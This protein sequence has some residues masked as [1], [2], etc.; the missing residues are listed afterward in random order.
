VNLATVPSVLGVIAL[1]F[2]AL[3]FVKVALQPAMDKPAKHLLLLLLAGMLAMAFCLFYIY[4]GMNRDW[5]RLASIEIGLAWWIGPSLYFYIRRLNGSAE[6][7]LRRWY[8][9]WVPA[10]AIE[11]LLL[12][13]FLR[14]IPG[15]ADLLGIPLNVSRQI[16]GYVWMGFHLQL[17]LYILLA[18]PQLRAYRRRLTDNYSDLSVLN[19]RWLTF[20][21]CGFLGVILAERLL[22]AIGVTS[23]SLSQ[24]AGSTV[25]LFVIVLMSGALGHSRLALASATRPE[26]AA[27]AIAGAPAV[28]FDVRQ[29][30]KYSRSRLRDDSAQ[31]YLSK[32]QTLMATERAFLESDLSLQSLAGRIKLSPHHLSQILNE[33]LHKNFYDYINEQRVEHARQLLQEPQATITGVA[34]D[35][36]FNSKNSFYNA[37][38]RHAG[39]SPSEFRRKAGAAAS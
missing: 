25:Y 16:V 18:L 8:W 26:P 3:L 27:P 32:L 24:T 34:F 13:F 28:E 6:P 4:A 15:R 29:V 30:E 22:P 10:I 23:T 20:C 35:S 2:L 5:P 33:K 7:F 12:P 14:N 1:A 21:C 9:Q 31:Y 19:L 37:F 38:R 39:M 17:T 11:I 36:G